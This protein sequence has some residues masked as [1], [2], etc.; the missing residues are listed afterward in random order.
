MAQFRFLLWLSDW[1]NRTEIFE[2]E[3]DDGNKIKSLEKHGI[4]LSE[5]E[6][7]FRQKKALLLGRQIFPKV[8]E[9]RFCLI[10]PT[11]AGRILSVVF[12]LRGIKVR[13]ISNRAAS[14][15]EKA[16]YEENGQTLKNV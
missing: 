8:E 5:V 14:K 16:L 10:G 15:K 4:H 13:P 2:F 9:E 1:Y 12:T 11:P 7:V 3:W 6:A